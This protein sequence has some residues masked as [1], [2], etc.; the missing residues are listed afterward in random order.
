MKRPAAS[1]ACGVLK[2]PSQSLRR[3]RP[4]CQPQ[5]SSAWG[6]GTPHADWVEKSKT[7]ILPD[8]PWGE[9]RLWCAQT[10]H[11]HTGRTCRTC[12]HKS[13]DSSWGPHS[14]VVLNILA[15]ERMYGSLDN[16]NDAGWRWYAKPQG[17]AHDHQ[18]WP[19]QSMCDLYEA[20]YGPLELPLGTTPVMPFLDVMVDV[21]R[22]Q[23]T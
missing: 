20:M 5:T 6:D 14:Q 9:R 8:G 4:R 17:R 2:K 13:V 3:S 12:A 19:P 21:A 15:S 18:W 7:K 10:L 22:A 16:A 1:M 23:S 11:S